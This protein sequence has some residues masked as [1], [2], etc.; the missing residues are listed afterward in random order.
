MTWQDFGAALGIILGVIEAIR[1]LYLLRAWVLRKVAEY[2][3]KKRQERANKNK[4]DS[5]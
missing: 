5:N 4:P 2:M 3:K 1:L